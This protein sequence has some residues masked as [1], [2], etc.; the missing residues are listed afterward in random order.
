MNP[1][2]YLT[3]GYRQDTPVLVRSNLAFEPDPD[4]AAP[5]WFAGREE[6]QLAGFAYGDSLDRLAETPY[7]IVEPIGSGKIVLFLDDPGFRVYW[8]GLHRLLLNSLLVAPS[9]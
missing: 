9:F 2:H 8:F 5:L 4:L 3:L 6:I 1:H 7:V